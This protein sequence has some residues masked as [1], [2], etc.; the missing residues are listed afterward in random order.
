M[1]KVLIFTSLNNVIIIFKGDILHKVLTIIGTYCHISP[2]LSGG[3]SLGQP[4]GIA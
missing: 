3:A 1:K 2:A 4:A